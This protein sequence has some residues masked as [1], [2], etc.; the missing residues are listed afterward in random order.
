MG[1]L[2]IF[3]GN[4]AILGENKDAPGVPLMVLAT[5]PWGSLWHS[6]AQIVTA[7]DFSNVNI[8]EANWIIAIEHG[9]RISLCSHPKGKKKA[10][11]K[12]KKYSAKS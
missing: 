6:F 3:S 8:S 1:K 11:P 2:M 9:Y 10:N 7:A 5:F 4:C 12:H